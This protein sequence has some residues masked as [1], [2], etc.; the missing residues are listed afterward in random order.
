[1]QAASEKTLPPLGLKD[2]LWERV[3]YFS[4]MHVAALYGLWLMFT[5]VQWQ[6]NVFTVVYAFLTGFG[7]TAGNHRLYTHRTY[8]AKLPL[9]IM[10]MIFNTMAFHETTIQWATDHRVHHKNSDTEKDPHNAKRG[11][12]YCHIGWILA[13]RN[14]EVLAECAKVDVSDLRNDKVVAF[15]EKYYN[16]LMPLL[17][18]ILPTIIPY[19]CWGESLTNAW[20]A[21]V[22]RYI[23]VLNVTWTVRK[24]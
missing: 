1:M 10:L 7:I 5:Q 20:H 16:I 9:N 11:F 15:Q 23:Y 14:P 8:K 17:C 3:F 4:Y 22:F 13:R 19:Y 24:S 21:L 2:I 6:T 12:F 18:F